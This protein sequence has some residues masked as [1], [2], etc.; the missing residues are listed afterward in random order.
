VGPPSTG[1][2]TGSGGGGGGSLLCTEEGSLGPGPDGGGRSSRKFTGGG[3]GSCTL[4]GSPGGG[5][6]GESLD[7]ISHLCGQQLMMVSKIQSERQDLAG[8]RNKMPLL[9]IQSHNWS[10]MNIF[11]ANP[12]FFIYL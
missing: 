6:R 11:G 5:G 1:Q 3:G 8:K 4:G 12:C 7:Q 9:R 10:T 2:F